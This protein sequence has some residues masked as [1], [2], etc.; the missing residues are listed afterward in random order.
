MP[1][2]ERFRTDQKPVPCLS[3]EQPA[4]RGE[5]GLVGGPVD[6]PLHLPTKDGDLVTEHRDLE[7][8][9][10][11]RAHIRAEQVEDSAQEQIEERAE[12]GAALSQIGRVPPESAIG[13]VNPTGCYSEQHE[14]G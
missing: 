4:R 8:R 11:H 12:H 5:Q 2:K 14:M 1:S 7:L 6:G 13:F 10:S 3:R 9:L